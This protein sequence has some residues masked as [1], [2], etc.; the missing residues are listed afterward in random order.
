MWLADAARLAGEFVAPLS[1]EPYVHKVVAAG[2]L[3]RCQESVRDID[4]LVASSEPGKVMERF[5]SLPGVARVQEHGDTK[6]SVRTAEGVQVDC[7]VIDKRSYGAALVYFTG[8]KEFN[9]RLRQLAQKRGYKV[10]EYGVFRNDRFVCG[11]TEEDVFKALGLDYIEP[12][13]RQDNGEISLAAKHA[14][15]ALVGAGDIAG[16]CTAFY[17]STGLIPSPNGRGAAARV[18]GFALRIIRRA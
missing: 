13:L 9:V 7:R 3:R 4:I 11:A 6:S 2:S 8:S 1:G 15:P 16:D 17:W 10:N 5:I 18:T 12:E 14:L